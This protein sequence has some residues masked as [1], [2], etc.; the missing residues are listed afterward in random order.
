MAGILDGL[1]Q[2]GLGDLENA[3]LYEDSE[4]SEQE[5]QLTPLQKQLQMEQDFIFDKTYSCPVCDSEFKSKTVKVGKAKLV[6]TDMDLRPKYEGIDMLKYD[7][8]MCPKCGY[9]A[10]GRYFKT[11][12][13]HQASKIRETISKVFKEQKEMSQVYTYEEALE[14]YKLALASTIVKQGKASEKAYIC[15][16]T[17]W[18]IRGRNE[19]LDLNDE[20]YAA[21]KAKGEEEEKE[22]LKNALEGFLAARQNESYPMCGMD[23]ATVD[24]LIAVIALRFDQF[25]VSSRL[26]S[27][28]LGASGTN[29]RIKDR[30]RDL[31]EVLVN[32]IKE[33]RK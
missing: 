23:E 9:A 24:Y 10:L 25:D 22:F 15:L 8:V 14:R 13:V 21:K 20:E 1:S 7:I 33:S 3:N 27:G 26:I 30:A 17:A 11:L 5:V 32:K 18:L 6:G 4:E 28:I 29:P 31:R 12:S 16:K 19:N 2:F